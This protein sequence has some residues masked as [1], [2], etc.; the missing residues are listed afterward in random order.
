MK[1]Y[2]ILLLCIS[3]FIIESMASI[4]D[5]IND[6]KQNGNPFK[7]ESSVNKQTANH[8][9]KG[10]GSDYD[11]AMNSLNSFS[12][13]EQ[14]ALVPTMGIPTQQL[15]GPGTT[16]QHIGG[17]VQGFGD[18]RYDKRMNW[19]EVLNSTDRSLEDYRAEKR[20]EELKKIALNICIG[21]IVLG[22]IISLIIRNKNK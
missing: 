21:I 5:E 1:K 22:F 20:N 16:P 15:S 17:L 7:K 9:I 13:E 19:S 12:P 14:R 2:F 18:S 11:S 4:Y 10:E 8:K 3:L 6:I